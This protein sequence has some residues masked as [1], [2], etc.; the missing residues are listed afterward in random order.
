MIL[1]LSTPNS[2][3][4][5]EVFEGHFAGQD[6]DARDRDGDPVVVAVGAHY[7]GA[8]VTREDLLLHIVKVR[9]LKCS[10]P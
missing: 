4:L 6:A 1:R 8:A 3:T 5:I 2:T 10:N 7:R 9:S